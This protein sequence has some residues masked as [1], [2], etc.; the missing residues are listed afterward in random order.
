MNLKRFEC[1]ESPEAW[2]RVLSFHMQCNEP[3]G[4]FYVKDKNNLDLGSYK[5]EY[6]VGIVLNGTTVLGWTDNNN[7]SNIYELEPWLSNPPPRYMWGNNIGQMNLTYKDTVYKLHHRCVQLKN[8]PSVF[9]KDYIF[10]EQSRHILWHIVLA[11]KCISIEKLTQME[12]AFMDRLVSGE[13]DLLIECQKRHHLA[14]PTRNCLRDFIENQYANGSLP[15][16]YEPT[17]SILK[18]GKSV[19]ETLC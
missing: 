2:K 16:N 9:G 18:L 14:M 6:P 13:P 11:S 1:D 19:K 4:F 10:F 17:E 12:L 15:A 8:P 3:K 5:G 7:P